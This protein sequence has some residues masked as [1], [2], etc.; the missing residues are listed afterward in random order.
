MK[1]SDHIIEK[2]SKKES[3]YLLNDYEDIAIEFRPLGNTYKCF[4][5]IKGRYPYE[6][7]GTTNLVMETELGGKIITKAQYEKY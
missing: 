5:K 1:N 7:E 3:A 4:A 2:F 6:L